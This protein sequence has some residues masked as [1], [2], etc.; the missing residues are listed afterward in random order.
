MHYAVRHLRD[1]E[2][3]AKAE[4][5]RQTRLYERIRSERLKAEAIAGELPV[6]GENGKGEDGND[7]VIVGPWAAAVALACFAGKALFGGARRAT[8]AT[9][10]AAAVAV[11]GISLAVIGTPHHPPSYGAL[12]ARPLV[13]PP[14][15][16]ST[17]KVGPPK[18][19]GP[20]PLAA[21]DAPTEG[22][23]AGQP[24]STGGVDVVRS[25]I[26]PDP[27]I[28]DPI[29]TDP[30]IPTQPPSTPVSSKRCLVDV[31]PMLPL[32]AL[33]WRKS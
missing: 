18:H 14:G 5:H 16:R 21:A 28:I 8:V 13:S 30:P 11:G 6:N 3:E 2:E 9:S 26:V 20:P 15:V 29:P 25:P 10:A 33:C 32:A 23:P 12:P 31:R 19:G 7:N 24:R 22:R 4:V 27:P 17:P 1:L